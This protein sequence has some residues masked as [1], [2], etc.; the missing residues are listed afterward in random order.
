MTNIVQA[1]S[2]LV[3]NSLSSAVI[4]EII[5]K[6][7]RIFFTTSSRGGARNIPT[8]G[9]ELPTRGLKWQKNAVC[10]HHFAKVPPTGTQ[11]FLRQWARCFKQW[12]L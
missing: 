7:I 9:L 2:K 12:G 1:L 4:L 8:E 11:H 10:V 3:L 6:I 5:G